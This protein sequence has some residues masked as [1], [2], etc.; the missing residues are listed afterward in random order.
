M[1][2]VYWGPELLARISAVYQRAGRRDR[3]AIL[4]AVESIGE[5]L[6]RDPM[7]TGESRDSDES[8]IAIE[9]PVA[10]TFRVDERSRLVRVSSVNIL[11]RD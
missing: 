10:V 8:R 11:E 7:A 2:R 5:A 4:S 1:Y 9:G 6:S 3:D